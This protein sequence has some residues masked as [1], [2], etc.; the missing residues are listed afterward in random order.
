MTGRKNLLLSIV[1][2]AIVLSSL[3]VASYAQRPPEES[4]KI[5]DKVRLHSIRGHAIQRGSEDRQWIN[6]SMVLV[7]EITAMNQS[8]I[9]VEIQEGS[10]KIG[11]NGYA[12]KSG[13]ARVLFQKFGWMNIVGN[14]TGSDGTT[15]RFHLEGM[16]HIERQMLVIVGLAG[17]FSSGEDSYVLRLVTRIEKVT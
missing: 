13:F 8:R 9:N 11:D 4:S 2:V 10:I 16:L 1:L 12:V 3:T 14:A 15:F 6:A 17:P 7:G 5:G